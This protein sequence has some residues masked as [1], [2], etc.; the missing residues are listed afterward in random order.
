MVTNTS[1][2]FSRASMTAA[3]L[4]GTS[5]QRVDALPKARGEHLFP[6]DH[7]LPNMLWL[8]VVRSKKPNARILSID[9]TKGS[10]TAGVVAILTA[11]DIPGEN[12]FGLLTADQPVLCEDRVRY[13]GEPIVVVAAETDEIARRARDAVEVVYEELPLV[14]DPL[15]AEQSIALHPSGNICAAI[16]LGHGDPA[17]A[18]DPDDENVEL[19]YVTNRQEHA[20]L[21]TEAGT[22]WIDSN[23]ILT[24]SVGG[25]NPFHDR[26][27]T[28][29]ALGL[30]VER[31]RILNPMMGG[32]FGGKEDCN[33][34]ILLALVTHKTGRPARLMLDR[35][36]SLVAGV[37]RHSFRVRYKVAAARDGAL[38]TLDV[39]LLADA[40]A[41]TTL[42]PA[43]VGQAAE[44]ASGPYRFRASSVRAKAVF[45][46]NG[47]ASAFRGFGNPQVVIGIEQAIDTLAIRTGL[48]PFEMRRRNLVKKGE[49]AGAGYVMSADTALPALLDAAEAG[50]IWR[51]RS[52]FRSGGEPW[53]RRGVGV[54]A[55]WQGYG[56]GADL[57]NGAA[58]RLSLTSRGTFR[59]EVGTP[60]LG[61]G[62]ITAFLQIAG[63]ALN[64]GVEQFECI[65]G[66]S[67]GPNSGSSHAS[68][69][70]YVVGNAVAPVA[71]ELRKKIIDAAESHFGAGAWRLDRGTVA[72][73]R[74][75][76]PLPELFSRTGSL[77]VE[78]SYRPAAATPIA[79]G[80]PHAGYGYWV[81]V[82]ALEVDGLT[83]EI[84][85]NAVENYVDT[86]KTINPVGAAGQCEGGFAQGL[87]YALYENAIY[88]GGILRNPTFSNYNIP[89]IKDVPRRFETKFFETP[90]E[91]NP[92]GVRGIAEIGLT[93]VAATVAN[94]VHDAI[95]IRFSRFPILPEMVLEALLAGRRSPRP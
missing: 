90:D 11:A 27:Q 4:I 9:T 67:L 74:E 57:E 37:K 80:I 6:S 8:Q 2:A 10:A 13:A 89:S 24:V 52:R 87:G 75:E 30:P 65:A 79:P 44:H 21:E 77:S 19:Q 5:Q 81:Q 38:R 28:A 45:T 17:A 1:G 55:I 64:A 46:N 49:I 42:S 63:D 12:R 14:D 61:E 78:E 95:G 7:V 88:A 18:T 86:G 22:S 85:V 40:G 51:T 29:S 47:N 72:R 34:Q 70:I 83:G 94:A 84:A 20:F 25:Q 33:V 53:V 26:R 48:S 39:E 71:E 3:G 54:S 62:N 56:L 32:A 16:S 60:D 68:R 23:G 50:E 76:I 15:R 66:D 82:M 58:V 31:V 73:E 41:Y 36:E 35:S 43:V 91:T 92:L 69:T 59:L 93:P